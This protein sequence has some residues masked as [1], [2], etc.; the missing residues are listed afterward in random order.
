MAIEIAPYLRDIKTYKLAGGRY[1]LDRKRTPS[2]L[3]AKDAIYKIMP[4]HIINESVSTQDSKIDSL[5]CETRPFMTT[6]WKICDFL[7]D[8]MQA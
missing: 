1:F 3:A 4:V 5:F 2:C 8:N 6:G 7:L